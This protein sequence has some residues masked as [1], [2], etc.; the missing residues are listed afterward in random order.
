MNGADGTSE[1]KV[2][3]G[4]QIDSYIK[5]ADTEECPG[6][7]TMQGEGVGPNKQ[8]RLELLPKVRQATQSLD[9][10]IKLE[11][12]VARK[13]RGSLVNFQKEFRVNGKRIGEIDIELDKVIIEVTSGVGKRKVGQTTKLIGNEALNP[14]KKPVILFAPNITPGRIKAVEQA[15]GKVF[16]NIN[17]LDRFLRN[18]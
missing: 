16:T 5:L 3:V 8:N 7:G 1:D 9:P 18:L 14:S 6:P 17:E 12:V 15:G 2:K 13:L 10:D 4:Q 11:G